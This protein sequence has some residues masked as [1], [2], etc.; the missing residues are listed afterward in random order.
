MMAPLDPW[1]QAQRWVVSLAAHLIVLALL[2]TFH[3]E[4]RTSPKLVQVTS[5]ITDAPKEERFLDLATDFSEKID[6]NAKVS[7]T[8]AGSVGSVAGA[9]AAPALAPASTGAGAAGLAGPVIGV[10]ARDLVRPLASA[11]GSL[12]LDQNVRGLVGAQ[13]TSSSDTGSV[14][15]ITVE[16]LRQLEKSKVLVCWLM[17]ASLSLQRRREEIIARFDRIYKELGELGGKGKNPLL[18]AIVAFGQEV[19]F[20]TKEPTADPEAIKK[21]VRSIK[22]DESGKEF[23]FTAIKAATLKYRRLQTVDQ[24]TIMLIVLTDEKGDDPSLLDETVTLVKKNRV[25]VYIFGPMAPFGRVTINV[26]IVEPESKEV[27]VRPIERGPE[28]VQVERLSIPYWGRGDQFDLFGSGF[29]PYSLTRIARESGGIY[30]LFDDGLIGGPK[31]NAYDMLEYSPDSL[32]IGDYRQMIAKHPLRAAI[33][34]AAEESHGGIEAPEMRFEMANLQGRLTEAQR[35][36]AQTEH[37]ADRGLASL[38]AVEKLRGKEASKRWQAQFDLSIGRLLATK[39]RCA[40]YN[41]AL[42]Q[43]KVTPRTPTRKPN[44]AWLLVGD[45]AIAV[46]KKDANEKAAKGATNVKK[47]DSK[48]TAQAEKDAEAARQYLKRVVEEHPGTPWARLAERELA[49]PL[50]FRWEETY[51]KPPRRPNEP[52]TAA[53]KEAE[54]RNKRRAAAEKKLKGL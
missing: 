22:T 19:Q 15:R 51:V 35:Q 27:F 53:D 3:V 41:W 21:A 44:N 38:R 34:K 9:T 54:E 4:G 26:P 32:S 37:L 7:L 39:V 1:R 13:V 43:M 47:A 20:V 25:L 8:T 10:G 46:G 40:E 16:I 50:G 52:L 17:D 42:A 18:T 30:F 45:N 31:F 36:V 2:L 23:V 48:V 12:N 11:A 6:L 14:D 49:T 24:R 28:S 5:A 29:G 33:I